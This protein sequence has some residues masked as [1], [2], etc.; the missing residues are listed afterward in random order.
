VRF[1]KTKRDFPYGD[2]NIPG[3]G[4]YSPTSSTHKKSPVAAIGNSPKAV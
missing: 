3:P 2:L 1:G 4:A